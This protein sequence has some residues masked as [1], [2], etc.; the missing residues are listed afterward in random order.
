MGFAFF[1]SLFFFVVVFEVTDFIFHAGSMYL[2]AADGVKV[3][4]CVRVL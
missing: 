3:C 2:S 4:V 1:F